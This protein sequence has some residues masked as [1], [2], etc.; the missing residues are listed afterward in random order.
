M[1]DPVL[2]TPAATWRGA[3]A[4]LLDDDFST[5]LHKIEVPVLLPWGDAD[6]FSTMM[7]HLDELSR[8]IAQKNGPAVG[9]CLKKL[10]S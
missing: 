3:F 8:D 5:E 4:A 7:G 2:R 1:G 10:Q 6:A 9:E